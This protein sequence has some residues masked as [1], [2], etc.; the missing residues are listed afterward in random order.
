MSSALIDA[1][2][3]LR[4]RMQ[5][6]NPD[7]EMET[8]LRVESPAEATSF[9]METRK[10]TGGAGNQIELG[11]ETSAFFG[12][13]HPSR[14]IIIRYKG[15]VYADRSHGLRVTDPPFGVDIALV[16]LPP[17]EDYRQKVVN[18]HRLSHAPDG[19]GRYDL[20]VRNPSHQDVA[21]WRQSAIRRGSSGQTRGGREWGYY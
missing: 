19:R 9:W 2:S 17:G 13:P 8:E 20:V 15:K 21:R 12:H 7:L 3:D 10:I 1:Y 18:F 11:V 14:T 5:R 4:K 16:Y 6:R